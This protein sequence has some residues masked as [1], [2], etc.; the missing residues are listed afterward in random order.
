MEYIN[1]NKFRRHRTMLMLV[2]LASLPRAVKFAITALTCALV[3]GEPF[4]KTI[5]DVFQKLKF[6]CN[7]YY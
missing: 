7:N 6:D 2:C 5:G 3:P 1:E 4:S